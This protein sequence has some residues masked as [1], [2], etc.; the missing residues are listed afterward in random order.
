MV[1]VG[2]S[3]C[4][5]LSGDVAV[6]CCCTGALHVSFFGAARCAVPTRRPSAFE[7]GH[8]PY[9]RGSCERNGAV[10]G[11]CRLRS[12]AAVVVSRNEGTACGAWSCSPFRTSPGA[13]PA[14]PSSGWNSPTP[15]ANPTAAKP[16][17]GRFYQGRPGV[18][19]NHASWSGAVALRSQTVLTGSGSPRYSV[20]GWGGHPHFHPHNAAGSRISSI[21]RC[22]LGNSMALYAL[23]SRSAT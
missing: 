21:S 1:G 8:I 15:P 22:Q 14:R 17:D 12:V 10:A 16:R 20:A 2:G 6:F 18:Y 4:S 11:C 5:L 23:D 3:S 13:F 7:A 19:V 9:W